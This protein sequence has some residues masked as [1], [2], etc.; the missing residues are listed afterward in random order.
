MSSRD[1]R[2]RV[3]LLNQYFW[4]DEAA[5]A[6]LATDLAEDLVARGDEVTVVA[7]AGAYAGPAAT[8]RR[9]TYRGIDIRR[10]PA[11]SFGRKT[12]LHRVA[13]YATFYA[14]AAL[15]LARAGRHDVIIVLTTPPL[16]NT[17]GVALQALR[18]ERLV[19]WVMDVYPEIAVALGVFPARGLLTAGLRAA[20]R[21]VYRRA[22]AVVAL[23]ELMAE[24]LVAAGAPRDRVHVIHNW[25]DGAAITPIPR[26]QNAFARELGLTDEL[27]IGY[28]G[29][30]GNC[31]DVTTILEAAKLLRDRRDILWL[32]IGDGPRRAEVAAAITRDG[33]H[34]QLL[35][36]QPRARL[37]ESLSAPDVHLVTILPGFEGLLVPSKLYGCLAAGRA[38]AYVGPPGTEVARII[39]DGRCGVAVAP[40]DAHGLAQQV[41]RMRG[42]SRGMGERA[43]ATF[44]TGFGRERLTAAWRAVCVGRSPRATAAD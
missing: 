2:M 19:L 32:F 24:R 18:G 22:D 23:G 8:C 16:L 38:V 43:R 3:L 41:T 42:A 17:L 14:G 7:S 10:V 11:T 13:D 44:T 9:E 37:A 40:G 6:Q 15:E 25:A 36:Y 5:T 33:L 35:P 28:S 20:A 4:P 21:L 1:G 34:A 29:N 27:V 30:F 31:H 26:A 12:K 39:G